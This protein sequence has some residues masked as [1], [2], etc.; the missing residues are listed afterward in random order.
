MKLKIDFD[1]QIKFKM[2]NEKTYFIDCYL[3]DSDTYIEI[4]GYFR[5]DAEEKWNWF[6]KEYP[7]SELWNQKKL[8]ELGILKRRNLAK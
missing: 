4:K 1:W 5:K 8:E 6:H 7:N 3:K 2:P